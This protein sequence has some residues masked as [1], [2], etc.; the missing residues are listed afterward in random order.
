MRLPMFLSILLASA[1]SAFRPR[2]AASTS[3]TTASD[4]FPAATAGIQIA[5]AEGA[6]MKLP[7]LLEEFSKVTGVTLLMDPETRSDVAKCSTGLNRSVDVPAPEVYS[8]VET[9]LLQHGFYLVP[10]HDRDPRI[11]TLVSINQTGG[12]RTPAIPR[13]SCPREI[14]SSTRAIPRWSSPRSSTFR[15]P[16]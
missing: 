7:K 14:S 11:A 2:R 9:I 6:E 1:C 4:P 16:T 8:V 12:D 15:T 10:A 3:V 5:V 13:S